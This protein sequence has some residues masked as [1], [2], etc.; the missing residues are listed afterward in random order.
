MPIVITLSGAIGVEPILIGFHVLP[1]KISP[2]IINYLVFDVGNL[3]AIPVF[4]SAEGIKHI[5]KRA[6]KKLSITCIRKN[7]QK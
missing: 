7:T 3:I 2:T 5:C 6:G 1:V 4:V